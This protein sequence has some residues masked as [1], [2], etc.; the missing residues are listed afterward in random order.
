MLYVILFTYACLVQVVDVMK[1]NLD[2]VLERD[3]KLTTLENR[4]GKQNQ[5]PQL[6]FYVVMHINACSLLLFI[7]LC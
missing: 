5:T 3:A 4:A 1:D 7:D 2:K 6:S